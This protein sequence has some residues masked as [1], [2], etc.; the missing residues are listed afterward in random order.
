MAAR[1]PQHHASRQ[2][3]NHPGRKILCESHPIPKKKRFTIS[4]LNSKAF[5]AASAR[6]KS[7][8][9]IGKR[10]PTNGYATSAIAPWNSDGPNAG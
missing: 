9:R 4:W 6:N 5:A 3:Y 10:L 2:Y 1:A 7:A 8:I